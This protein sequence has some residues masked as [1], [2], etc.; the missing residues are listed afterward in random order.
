MVLVIVPA[1]WVHYG[2][3]NLL[4][5]SDIALIVMMF[6]L[7][8]EN[9]LLASMTAIAV[10]LMEFVWMLGFFSGGNLLTIA[11]YMFDETIPLWL[12]GLSLFHFPMPAAVIYMLLKYG[13]DPRA[14][15]YQTMVAA[16]VLPVTKIAVPEGKNI[17]WVVRPDLLA[18]VP[19]PL[20][21]L[22]MFV[23]LFFVV[24]LPSH[25]LFKRYF[26]TADRLPGRT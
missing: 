18:E 19:L 23:T 8:M 7:W 13:Y 4:W 14:L 25:Y 26:N 17:N 22:G 20:Y 15:K 10:L 1:Y 12:R 9:R 2:P 3:S 11:G 6:A 21:L 24:Y 5:F 16:I